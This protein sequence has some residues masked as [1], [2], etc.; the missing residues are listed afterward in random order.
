MR[1]NLVL[2]LAGVIAGALVYAGDA[3]SAA[4]S[5]DVQY[6]DALAGR[7]HM[8]GTLG[9][10]PV[11]Y[12]AQGDWVLQHGF[13]RLHMEDT[14]RTAHYEAQVFLGY[15]AKAGDYVAH[16]LDRF[17]APGARVVA[18]GKREGDTL[19][20]VFPYAEGAFRDT[21]TLHRASH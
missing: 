15:D 6:L 21:F 14:H 4:P 9:A 19:V 12:D 1:W 17:G 20:I 5:V 11:R 8:N 16:W 13:L 2:S 3:L 18:T 10:K 7:W